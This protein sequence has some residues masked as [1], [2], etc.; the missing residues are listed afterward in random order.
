MENSSSEKAIEVLL[1]EKRSFSS[2]AAFA[3]AALISGPNARARLQ[4][5]AR[6][7]PEKF[8]AAAAEQL[9]WFKPWRKVLDWKLPHAQWFVGGKLNLAH[10]CLDR[11]LAG[12]RRNKAALI[13]EGET[14]ETRTL[15]YLQ[16]HREV[17]LFANALKDLGVK[18]GDRVAIYM[19][20]VPEA[21][22]AML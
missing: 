19:P 10:N 7:S 1:K 20:M 9:E 18:K 15:T 17:S 4:E 22:V 5:A 14:G 3:K 12:P 6:R 2:P 16:L 8:W 13:W 11:H 21:A